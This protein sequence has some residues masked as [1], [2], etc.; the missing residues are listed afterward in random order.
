MICITVNLNS[1]IIFIFLDWNLW[2]E[3]FLGPDSSV[4]SNTQL[5]S[6]SNDEQPRRYDDINNLELK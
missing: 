6:S 3:A 4:V 1:I 5:D 2:E